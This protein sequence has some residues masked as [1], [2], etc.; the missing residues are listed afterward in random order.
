MDQDILSS[1]R[2][3]E[4]H[5]A[6]GTFSWEGLPIHLSLNPA[7]KLLIKGFA[8]E[9]RL[10]NSMIDWTFDNHKQVFIIAFNNNNNNNL[11]DKS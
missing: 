9:I 11:K 2:V 5:R 1:F 7:F 10:G 8:V 3:L 4:P 6:V